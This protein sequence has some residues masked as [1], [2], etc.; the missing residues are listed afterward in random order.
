MKK[1]KINGV[2]YDIVSIEEYQNNKV[3]YDNKFTAIEKNGILYPITKNR[4]TPGYYNGNGLFGEYI[5]PE[6]SKLSEYSSEN[7]INF[8][9]VSSMKEMMEKNA[10]LR[11]IEREILCSSDNK[12]KPVIQEKDDP[13]MKALKEAVIAKDIDLD[14]Y[15]SRFGDNYNNDKRLF[16]RNTISISKLKSIANNL[17]ISLTLTLE[18]KSPDVPNPMGRKIVVNIAGGEDNE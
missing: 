13:E 15:E 7:I 16:K 5:N 14:K 2:I 10:A 1:G 4:K 9:S 12:F 18:D 3:L 6:P 17:D 11:D 8:E